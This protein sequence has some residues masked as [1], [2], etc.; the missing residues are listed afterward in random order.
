MTPIIAPMRNVK[1]TETDRSDGE[2]RHRSALF[3]GHEQRLAAHAARIQGAPCPCGSGKTYGDCCI[4]ADYD[5]RQGENDAG[6]GIVYTFPRDVDP[7]AQ[8]RWDIEDRLRRAGFDAAYK[9]TAR[10]DGL[11]ERLCHA[12]CMSARPVSAKDVLAYL[13]VTRFVGKASQ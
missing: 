12:I 6:T 1:A 5:S 13:K 7:C 3:A 4:G 10:Y 11:L 8:K 9:A 2:L